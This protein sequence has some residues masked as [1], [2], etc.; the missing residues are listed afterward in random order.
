[1]SDDR[2]KDAEAECEAAM[3]AEAVATETEFYTVAEVEAELAA[4]ERNEVKS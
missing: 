4:L 2:L 3:L 1:M